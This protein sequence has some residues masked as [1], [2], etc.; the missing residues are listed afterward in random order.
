LKFD[1]FPS[2]FATFFFSHFI[3]EITTLPFL[4]YIFFSLNINGTQLAAPHNHQQTHFASFSA[5]LTH[6]V[7]MS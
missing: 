6:K 2:L 3:K 1:A 7:M 5:Y 4:K